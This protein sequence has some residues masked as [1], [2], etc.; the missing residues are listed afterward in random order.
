MTRSQRGQFK[1]NKLQK[2]NQLWVCTRTNS[3]CSH[4]FFFFISFWRTEGKEGES[5]LSLKV[6]VNFRKGYSVWL[7]CEDCSILMLDSLIFQI[8]GGEELIPP[9]NLSGYVFNWAW[10][11]LLCGWTKDSILLGYQSSTLLKYRSQ[12]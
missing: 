10:N 8:N 7:L 11:K 5:C 2:P 3:K 1:H 12:I 4:P 9:F 6:M